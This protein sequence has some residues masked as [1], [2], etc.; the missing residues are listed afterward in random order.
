LKYTEYFRGAIPCY[1]QKSKL[2]NCKALQKQ[3][4]FIQ[5]KKKSYGKA[6]AYHSSFVRYWIKRSL[7]KRI[8]SYEAPPLHRGGFILHK[9]ISFGQTI[10]GGIL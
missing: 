7:L 2:Q 3:R 1:K 5:D 8:L 6:D 10:A 4:F 9:K